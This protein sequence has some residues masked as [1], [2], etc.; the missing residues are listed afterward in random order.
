[1]NVLTIII[2][3]L[4]ISLIYCVYERYYA[5]DM[6]CPLSQYHKNA[7]D[8]GLFILNI[9]T[10]ENMW[11]QKLKD[12]YGIKSADSGVDLTHFLSMIIPSDREKVQAA[13][14]EAPTRGYYNIQFRIKTPDNKIKVIASCGKVLYDSGKPILLAGYDIDIS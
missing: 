11:S 12:I 9:E 8:M 1:M 7:K 5:N 2:I 4:V 6:E 14:Q 3:V 13:F 10:G